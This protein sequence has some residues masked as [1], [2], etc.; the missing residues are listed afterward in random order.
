MPWGEALKFIFV[1]FRVFFGSLTKCDLMSFAFM[2]D[3][4]FFLS[5]EATFIITNV[6]LYVRPSGLG[7]NRIFSNAI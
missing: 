2:D 1:G 7:G 5:S 6:L 4:I 3:L